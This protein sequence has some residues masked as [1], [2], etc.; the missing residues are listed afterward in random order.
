VSSVPTRALHLNEKN[1][2]VDVCHPK[3]SYLGPRVSGAQVSTRYRTKKS[4]LGVDVMSE[5]VNYPHCTHLL[6][7]LPTAHRQPQTT[8]EGDVFGTT[9]ADDR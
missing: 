9:M 1:G 4:G 2:W 7:I 6:V 3:S 8:V 5:N